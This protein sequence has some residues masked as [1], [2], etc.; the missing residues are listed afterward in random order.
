MTS[1]LSFIHTCFI[2]SYRYGPATFVFVGGIVFIYSVVPNPVMASYAFSSAFLFVVSTTI[3]Y[4][5]I[6]IETANQESVTMLHAGSLI[7]LYMAKLL[8]SWLFTIPLVLYAVLFPVIFQS[9][10]RN[11]TVEEL[12]MS[13]LYHAALSWL[14]VSLTCWFS[15]KFIRSR[16]MSFLM[17][18]LVVVIT[19]CVPA[20]ENLLPERLKQ[21]IV[22]LPPLDQTSY[23]L[24]NYDTA[25]LS[26]KLS[27][28]G[29]S[30]VYGIILTILFLLL[31]HKRKMD[32][33][34]F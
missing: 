29:A 7:K 30:L 12:C 24:M 17:L 26:M 16:L 5:L 9:F 23:V 15:S 27:A 32:F 31:L 6:D 8:Y 10:D 2:R 28:I 14:A 4:A 22:L 34:Q 33:S 18:S 25:S 19:F 21:A 11:P 1:L 3:C 20:I 13:F